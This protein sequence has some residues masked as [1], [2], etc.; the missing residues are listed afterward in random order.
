MDFCLDIFPLRVIL[1]SPSAK[2]LTSDFTKFAFIFLDN[3]LASSSEDF[4][5]IL[6]LLIIYSTRNVN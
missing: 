3:F 4:P 5:A 6:Q 1:L 2:T